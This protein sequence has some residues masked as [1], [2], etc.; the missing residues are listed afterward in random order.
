MA[1]P[2]TEPRQSVLT[3]TFVSPTRT[4]ARVQVSPP[5]QVRGGSMVYAVGHLPG[6]TGQTL[7]PPGIEPLEGNVWVAGF[8]KTTGGF[9]LGP[10]T[11]FYVGC[12]VKGHDAPDGR[13]GVF[14]VSGRFSDK[15]GQVFYADY[16][17]LIR[18]GDASFS[19]SQSGASGHA[20]LDDGDAEVRLDARPGP[21][22]PVW[23][24]GT[25]SYLERIAFDQVHLIKSD[26]QYNQRPACL[27]SRSI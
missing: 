13:E 25:S 14:I 27:G 3:P 5:F 21:D 7:L 2:L 11:A 24:S 23:Y 26:T 16:N 19:L 10:Y 15:A 17:R 6:T 9:V 1:L 8:Y 12:A 18:P 4:D 20:L 22:A